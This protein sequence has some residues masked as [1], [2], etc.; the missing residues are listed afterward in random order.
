[1]M[2]APFGR[3][4]ACAD[5]GN[6]HEVEFVFDGD[7][8]TVRCTCSECTGGHVCRHI[9]KFLSSSPMDS[10]VSKF[11]LKIERVKDDFR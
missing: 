6:Y 8:L 3:A 10:V 5:N 7:K 9:A 1:M 2:V 11:P 4:Y